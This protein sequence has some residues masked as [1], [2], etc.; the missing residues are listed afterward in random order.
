MATYTALLCGTNV[1]GRAIVRIVE[2]RS[3]CRELG[4]R[5]VVASIQRGNLV[6]DAD[7]VR[8]DELL[9]Q[10]EEAGAR[11]RGVAR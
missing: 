5:D 8:T 11:P 2:F 10:P 9:E 4:W 6:F 7:G 3:L 1:G